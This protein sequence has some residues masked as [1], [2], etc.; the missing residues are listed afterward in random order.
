MLLFKAVTL[1]LYS[2]GF[3]NKGFNNRGFS[4]KNFN[5]RDFS[6]KQALITV[7]SKLPNIAPLFK[8]HSKLFNILRCLVII[9]YK[10]YITKVLAAGA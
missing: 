9:A 5:S 3:N 10:S 4:N 7:Y 2:K 6:N 1:K 8:T